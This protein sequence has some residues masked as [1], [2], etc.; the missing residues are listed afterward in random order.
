MGLLQSTLTVFVVQPA[1]WKRK[2]APTHQQKVFIDKVSSFQAWDMPKL[3]L[4]TRGEAATDLT[5]RPKAIFSLLRLRRRGEQKKSAYHTRGSQAVSDPSTNRARRCLTCEIRRVRVHSTWYGGRRGKWL[6][7][8]L[9]ISSKYRVS[10]KHQALSWWYKSKYA[11]AHQQSA[12]M[13]WSSFS[14]NARDD[15]KF[16]LRGRAKQRRVLLVY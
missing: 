13:G 8:T 11:P 9:K 4:R 12:F 3:S 14:S 7:C 2:R 5:A 10:R 1:V 16:P 6:R 15:L